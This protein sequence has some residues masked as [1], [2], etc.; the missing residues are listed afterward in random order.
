MGQLM[1][2]YRWSLPRECHRECTAHSQS[3]QRWRVYRRE[4]FRFAFV[5]DG[6]CAKKGRLCCIW[7]SAGFM[8]KASCVAKPR[9]H[10][11]SG[12][13]NCAPKRNKKG[14]C[15]YGVRRHICGAKFRHAS[16]PKS[17]TRRSSN[18]TVN[19]GGQFEV[20]LPSS[21]CYDNLTCRLGRQMAVLGA[22]YTLPEPHELP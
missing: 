1:K 19:T 8:A 17:G 6:V 13:R 12:M 22:V 18:T 3:D 21:P 11:I 10:S 15:I 5:E 2:Y 4:I 7:A 14:L 16:L 9:C 20:Y